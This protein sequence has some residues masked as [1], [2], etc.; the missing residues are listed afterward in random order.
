[1][2]SVEI[3]PYRPGDHSS[4]MSIVSSGATEPWKRGYERT[5]TTPGPLA[6]RAAFLALAFAAVPSA[7]F[8]IILA[9]V[10]EA[11]LCLYIYHLFYEDK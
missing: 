8:F 5:F 9:G 1:M 3:R 10:Y 7:H 6:F 11:A 2:S 4:V